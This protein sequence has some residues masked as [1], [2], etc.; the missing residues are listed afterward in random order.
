MIMIMKPAP[1]PYRD[2]A[3]SRSLCYIIAPVIIY[4]YIF[5]LY[6]GHLFV[7]RKIVIYEGAA[8]MECVACAGR[9]A[10][11]LNPLKNCGT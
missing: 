1:D 11:L 4:Y 7:L 9:W 8:E 2:T 6:I 3:G 5:I 10:P